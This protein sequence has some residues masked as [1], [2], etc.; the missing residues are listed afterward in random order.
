MERS[1][2]EILFEELLKKPEDL[3]FFLGLHYGFNEFQGKT[4]A[5]FYEAALWPGLKARI[6]EGHQK[7]SR[8]PLALKPAPHSR[9]TDLKGDWLCL[10]RPGWPERL[11]VALGSEQY[12]TRLIYVQ[13]V[14]KG[15]KGSPAQKRFEE[16]RP[17][18]L[19][20]VKKQFPGQKVECNHSAVWF[21]YDG[22]SPYRSWDTE[23]SLTM[24]AE[25]LLAVKGRERPGPEGSLSGRYIDDLM[26]LVEIVDGTEWIQGAP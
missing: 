26:A 24:L 11:A 2:L 15:E 22:A 8:P 3:E 19:E 18:L 5:A 20:K 16:R 7:P 6:D 25:E 13:I 12:N 1:T 10:S 9:L 4:V 23:K 21:F 17:S 14:V